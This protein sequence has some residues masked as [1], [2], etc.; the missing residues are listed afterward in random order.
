MRLGIVG[1]GNM[2]RALGVRWARNGHQVLF[3]SRDPEKAE[4]ACAEAGPGALAGDADAAA[5]FG[6][7]ILYTVR[8]VL[9]AEL[10][11]RPE[12]LR[13]KVL[14][15]CNNSGILGFDLPHP[16]PGRKG[17][18]F[19]SSIPSLAERLAAGTPGARVVKAFNTVPARVIALDPVHLAA[20]DVSVFLCADDDRARSAVRGLVEELGFRAVDCGALERARLIEAAADLVRSQILTMGAG[21]LTTL[22][23]RTA[24][25]ADQAREDRA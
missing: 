20:A 12:A 17:L 11:R 22:S 14:V 13:G 21:P 16:V 25:E 19:V 2:G 3:G 10:L 23:L 24:Q 1:T 7:V 6:E 15:D 18:E 8:D 4:A 5:G 9:P